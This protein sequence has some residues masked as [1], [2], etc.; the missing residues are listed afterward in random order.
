M[1]S[2]LAL[3]RERIQSPGDAV[4]WACILEATAPKAGNVFPGQSFDNLGY[5]DFV[6]AAEIT[7][8]CLDGDHSKRISERMLLAVSETSNRCGSNV[9]LGIVL[10]LGPLFEAALQL[11]SEGVVQRSVEAWKRAIERVLETLDSTDGKNVFQAIA[12]A[13]AGG[14][15]RVDE[16]DIHEQTEEVD[17]IHAMKLAAD[18]DRIAL[19]FAD[20]FTDLLV[21]VLPV[22]ESSI[23]DAGDILTGVCSAHLK[24]LANAPDS[25]IAR[26]NDDETAARV[27]R[28]ASQVDPG[29][30]AEVSEFH[31]ALSPHEHH[32]LNPGTTADLMAASLFVLLCSDESF[33]E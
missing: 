29:N 16:M 33:A 20:G 19:Q 5:R 10:L 26:K 21:N 4:R 8:G 31:A 30:R 13:S 7:A 32:P 24:L 11:Q 6:E 15:G 2:P 23:E 17:L 25:L 3:I 27:M 28:M 12:L 18:R 14:L 1:A 9:N 22:V